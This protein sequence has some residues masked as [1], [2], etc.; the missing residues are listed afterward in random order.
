M[1]LKLITPPTALPLSIIDARQHLKQDITDDD[2][3]IAL[4]LGAAVEFAQAK[5][6]RQFVA[7]RYQLILDNFPAPNLMTATF[8]KAGNQYDYV[9]SIPRTP[10]IQ[11]VS[12]DYTAPDGTLKTLANTE[13]QVDTSYDPPRIS[14]A[15]GEQWPNA[16]AQINSVRIVFDAG[17][18]APVAANV[19]ANT[20]SIA[21]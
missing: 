1:N 12:I 15:F 9:I 16:Q 19:I 4:Y 3:L 21:G 13:F 20:V 7:A 11:V 6:N 2:N 14:P 8:G 10:L 18:I 17:Y 5:T